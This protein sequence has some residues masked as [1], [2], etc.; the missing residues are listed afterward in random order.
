MTDLKNEIDDVTI[1]VEQNENLVNKLENQIIEW[2]AFK[3]LCRRDEELEDIGLCIEQLNM[4]LCE[5][6]LL[7]DEQIN[8]KRAEMNELGDVGEGEIQ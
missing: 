3:K 5:E 4:E 8:Q 6:N 2:D 7:M 1:R